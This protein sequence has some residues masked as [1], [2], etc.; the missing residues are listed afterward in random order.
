MV[1]EPC[2]T[3][4]MTSEERRA[5]R[6]ARR[7]E[8]RAKK[9]SERQSAINLE[10]V[11]SMD[12]LYKSSW[13]CFEGVSWKS[14]AQRYMKDVLRNNYRTRQKLLAGE[15]IR[16]GTREFGIWERG[17]YRRI[18]SVQYPE[19][20]VQKSFAQ[21][22]L[23]P[24]IVPSFVR[25]NTANVKGRGTSD[26]LARLKRDLVNHYRLYGSNGYILLFDLK[27]FFG[28]IDHDVACAMQA[29]FVDDV[30]LQALG[31]SFI[32]EPGGKGLA[33][34]SE[35]NQNTAVATP[36]PI[37]HFI[38]ECCQPESFGRYMDDGYLIHNEKLALDICL[39]II[40]DRFAEMGLTV[41]MRKTHIAKLSRGFTWLKKRIRY[42]PNGRV[43]M[44]PSRDSVTRERRKLKAHAGMVSRGELSYEEAF[45]SYQ[46][47][48]GLMKGLD[49]HNITRGTDA[50]F[51]SFFS[52]LRENT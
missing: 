12:A 15:D 4:F 28:S 16:M 7:E 36:S 9:R 13:H 29:H 27:D 6:R 1:R 31:A 38:I 43:S 17:K 18:T 40:C 39:A 14:S 45:Q 2:G 32:G 11:A 49:S 26:A 41:N 46:S 30:R 44:R 48:L 42:G 33:L 51:D 23:V 47:W 10:A 52:G 50:M 34:G 19:R 24:A 35:P 21:N 25:N 5:A 37:D 3:P 22:A 20:V 8:K